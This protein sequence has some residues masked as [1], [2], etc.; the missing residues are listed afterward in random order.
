MTEYL[1]TPI[2]W[3]AETINNF[4]PSRYMDQTKFLHPPEFSKKP[5]FEG[6]V[7][8]ALM[9]KLENPIGY[10]ISFEELVKQKYQ[11][12]KPIVF[13]VDDYTR[14]NIH[15]KIILPLMIEKILSLGVAKEDFRV[16][17][18]TG[19]H[20][21]P[22]EEEYPTKMVGEFVYE[23]YRANI[24]SHDCDDEGVNIGI[25][26]AGTPMTF[27]KLVFEASIIVPITDSELHYFAGV[28]GTI[29]EICPGIAGRDTV[30]QNHPRMFDRKLGF[31][32]GCRLG[33]T[34]DNPVISDIKNMVNIL[35]TKVPI[36]G[37]DTIVTEG[38][39]VYLNAG[40]LVELH[41]EA[42]NL[43]V[44]MR[45]VK[46]PKAGGIVVSGMQSWGINLY[47]A[48][49]GIHAAWNAVKQDG[50]GIIIA[51]APLP[52]GVGNANYE[53]VMKETGEMPL[54]EGLEYIL[55]NYCTTETFKIG[56]QKPVDTM[57]IVKL[58]GE[59]N[60]KMIADWDAD[61]LRDYYRVNPIKKP[62]ES[63][64]DALRR[65]IT[66]YMSEKPDEII[67]IMDDPGLYV[68]I[69]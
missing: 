11:K 56:N 44:K 38:K 6:T 13:A 57:R 58:I 66:N 18:A 12:G 3:G 50:T 37:I 19:T 59:G 8:E 54:Q 26:D 28:A 69:Q 7:K 62:E 32:P 63:P 10:D 23:N 2:S 17:I 42:K 34:E 51:V 35:K 60:L 33:S 21:E 52:D 53:Q 67:Y 14:P 5:M 48:G 20:R 41:D 25:S 39:I 68:I 22:K 55:D 46:L 45:T 40:D 43:I 36:F 4:V 47:Q 29:K 65:E 49:K 31:V 16:L 9:K 27:D 1:D 64:V 30:R 61:Q 24:V 15:T